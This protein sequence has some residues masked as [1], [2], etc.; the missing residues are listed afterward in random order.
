MCQYGGVEGDPAIDERENLAYGA[1]P[2]LD[3]EPTPAPNILTKQV[4]APVVAG[5]AKDQQYQQDYQDDPEDAHGSS[6][7]GSL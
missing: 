1:R 6:T 7:T 5:A 2:Y 4:S 3:R